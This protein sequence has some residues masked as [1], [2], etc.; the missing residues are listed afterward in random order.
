MPGTAAPAEGEAPTA[1]IPAF[2][3]LNLLNGI[4]PAQPGAEA[5]AAEAPTQSATAATPGGIPLPFLAGLATESQPTDLPKIELP[6][7]LPD[8]DAAAPQPDATT[9][10][11]N[12]GGEQPSQVRGSA[13]AGT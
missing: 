2:P 8:A 3:A 12:A 9:V 10:A 11:P 5:P 7:E 13:A 4:A 6:T 1:A